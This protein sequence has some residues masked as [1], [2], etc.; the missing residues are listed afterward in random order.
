MST[1]RSTT[2]SR[3]STSSASTTRRGSRPSTTTTHSAAWAAAG[4]RTWGRRMDSFSTIGI[5]A[6]NHFTRGG[7]HFKKSILNFSFLVS[8]FCLQKGLREWVEEGVRVSVP[9]PDGVRA[10]DM[11]VQ[12]RDHCQNHRRTHETRI[13]IASSSSSICRPRESNCGSL[14]GI[15]KNNMRDMYA[16]TTSNIDA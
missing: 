12:G 3:V 15:T 8:I 10:Q 6:R 7:G 2:A 16:Y 1:A 14:R 13:L 5:Y 4:P 9:E 11:D